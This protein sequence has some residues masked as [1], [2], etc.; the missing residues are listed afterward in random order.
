MR[1]VD[2]S[3]GT[4]DNSLLKLDFKLKLDWPAPP[5]YMLQQ[6][7]QLIWHQYILHKKKSKNEIY[8]N[9]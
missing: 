1:I 8:W 6:K 7:L 3:V 4:V 9:L 2:N 5:N